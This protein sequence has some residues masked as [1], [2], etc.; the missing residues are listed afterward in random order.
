[1]PAPKLF[2]SSG[3]IAA[4]MGMSIRQ[5]QNLLSMFELH[6][7]VVHNG[8]VK[9]VSVDVFSR[10]LSE[11]DGTDPGERKRE[12]QEFLREARHGA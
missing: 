4:V 10:H 6:G 3:D 5:A 11:Q 9:L 1:M 2:L 8:R 7:K 12:I